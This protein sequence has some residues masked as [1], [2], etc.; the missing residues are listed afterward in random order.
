MCQS[1]IFERHKAYEDVDATFIDVDNDGDLD[2]YV[3]SGGNERPLTSKYYQDRFY[4]N[5][6][7]KFEY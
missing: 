1:E 7:N 3:V 2:L 4:E 5:N 6:N